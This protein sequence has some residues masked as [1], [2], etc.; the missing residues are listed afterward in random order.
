[1]HMHMPHAAHT[2]DAV[3]LARAQTLDEA[4]RSGLLPPMSMEERLAGRER[5]LQAFL[6]D[7]GFSDEA[8]VRPCG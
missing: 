6:N 4:S 1:M 5:S 8:G 3:R 2:C 7:Y